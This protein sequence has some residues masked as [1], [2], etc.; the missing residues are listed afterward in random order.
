MQQWQPLLISNNSP[1][2]LTVD[3]AHQHRSR[4][5][6]CRGQTTSILMNFSK[7]QWMSVNA[8]E[9]KLDSP[10]HYIVKFKHL[11]FI[12]F[13]LI[14]KNTLILSRKALPIPNTERS[15]QWSMKVWRFLPTGSGLGHQLRVVVMFC[16]SSSSKANTY[17]CQE[18]FLFFEHLCWGVYVPRCLELDIIMNVQ[19]RVYLSTMVYLLHME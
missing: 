9:Y 5:I 17:V 14:C 6:Y 19:T 11:R 18:D 15:T 8:Y 16:L 3:L 13:Q 12:H 4:V 7:I 1:G 2:L 10:I